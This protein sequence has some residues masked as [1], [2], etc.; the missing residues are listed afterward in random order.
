[1]Y[2]FMAVTDQP[3]LEFSK[4][5]LTPFMSSN[6]FLRLVSQQN[7]NYFW[8]KTFKAAIFQVNDQ[9]YQCFF[10]TF[11]IGFENMSSEK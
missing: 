1:M 9:S 6:V 2:H 7:A 11:S 10:F 4:K 8:E 3:I 5:R